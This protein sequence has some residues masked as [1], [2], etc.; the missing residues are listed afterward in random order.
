MSISTIAYILR[1]GAT[2]LEE[3]PHNEDLEA[4]HA[5]HHQALNNTEVKDSPLRTPDGAK[6]PVLSGAEVFLVP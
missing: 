6:I 3:E 1:R 4:R 5:N 2:Y